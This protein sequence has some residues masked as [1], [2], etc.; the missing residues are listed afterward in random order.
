MV[1]CFVPPRTY[2][3]YQTGIYFGLDTIV[4]VPTLTTAVSLSESEY[5]VSRVIPYTIKT[6]SNLFQA[7]IFQ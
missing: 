2:T 4:P 5:Q 7:N 1:G 3:Q 6:S